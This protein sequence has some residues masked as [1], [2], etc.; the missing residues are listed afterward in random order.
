MGGHVA[1]MGRCLTIQ[2]FSRST[3]GMVSEK[4]NRW[5]DN[6]KINLKKEELRI[7]NP[8]NLS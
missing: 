6:I 1:C 4:R 8:L 5:K 3:K 7:W 2:N